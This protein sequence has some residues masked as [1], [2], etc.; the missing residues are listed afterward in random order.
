MQTSEQFALKNGYIKSQGGRIRRFP[1]LQ[2]IYAKYGACILDDLELWKQLHET[3]GLYA[4]A[5]K[6]RRELKNYLNNAKNFQIQSLAASIVNR[7]AIEIARQF[8]AQ[9]LD[10]VIVAQIHD[11]LLLEAQ[12]THAVQAEQIMQQVME[13]IWELPVQLKAKPKQIQCYGDAK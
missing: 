12:D 3:P 7:A 11:E 4:Q 5:K 1:R 10:A 13:N 8:E 9:N 6:D 2:R